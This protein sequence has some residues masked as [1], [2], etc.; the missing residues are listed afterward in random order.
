[1]RRQAIEWFDLGLGLERF[2]FDRA[3]GL[4]DLLIGRRLRQADVGRDLVVGGVDRRQRR[5]DLGRRIDA[6]DQRGIQHDAIAGRGRPALA[7]HVF[8]Q[9]AQVLA[10][11][12]DRNA[13]HR[14]RIWTG[15]PLAA[16]AGASKLAMRSRS[17]ETK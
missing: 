7:I 16:A 15:G 11:V 5:F 14:R 2:D 12:I 6:G 3:S 4:H 10:N 1:M 13:D 17:T 8:V 9:V